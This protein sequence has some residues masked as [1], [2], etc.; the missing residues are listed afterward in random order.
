[1]IADEYCVDRFTFDPPFTIFERFIPSHQW[2]KDPQVSTPLVIFPD[3]GERRKK[4]VKDNFD[5]CRPSVRSADLSAASDVY[6]SNYHFD[7]G[8]E[9]S[10]MLTSKTNYQVPE[11]VDD[12]LGKFVT[13]PVAMSHPLCNIE[14]SVNWLVK[15]VGKLIDRIYSSTLRPETRS[16]LQDAAL[17]QN[18]FC[19]LHM[20]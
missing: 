1:M 12:Y 9:T 10:N 19:T 13:H 7:S 4:Q 6:T 18:I 5:W 20:R 11:S 17:G 8:F 3:N 2:N 15:P 14:Q 16:S